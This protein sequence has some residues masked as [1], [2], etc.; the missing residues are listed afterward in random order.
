MGG[1]ESSDSKQGKTKFAASLFSKMSWLA[2]IP[3]MLLFRLIGDER[4]RKHYNQ[5]LPEPQR[6][7]M[8]SDRMKLMIVAL[9]ATIGQIGSVAAAFAGVGV[10]GMGAG[11]V[12]SRAISSLSLPRMESLIHPYV[13]M[14]F[15]AFWFVGALSWFMIFTNPR[16]R[17]SQLMRALKKKHDH[18]SSEQD[19]QPPW[20]Y[21]GKMLF[22]DLLDRTGE[23]AVNDKPLWNRA[24]F[25]PT[26]DVA[27]IPGT[28]QYILTASVE[29]K[30]N[31]TMLYDRYDEWTAL[32]E[33]K[34][35][36]YHWMLGEYVN[37]NEFMWKDAYED[38]SILFVGQSGSGKT[39]AMKCWLTNFVCKHPTT[40]IVICDLKK[41]GDWDSFAPLTENGMVVKSTEE[42]LLAISYFEDIL[43]SRTEHMQKNGYKN[44]R[45]WS[46]A[47]NTVV[48]PVLLIVDEFPQM[49]GPLKWDVYSRRDQTPAN[50]LF[51]LY[52]T[53]RSFG[54]WV[55]LGSQF[56]GSD[57]VPSEMNKNIKLHV[58][59]KVGSS[60]E[61]MQWINDEAAFWLGKNVR[62]PDGSEDRQVGYAYV[63][64]KTAFVRY[65]YAD[66]WLIVHEFLKY[67]VRT[68]EGKEHIQARKMGIPM[69]IRDRLKN[70]GG[71]KKKLTSR[72]RTELA[73]NEAAQAKFEASYAE[74]R[75]TPHQSL[76][77]KKSPLGT[78]WN[79]NEPVEEY[80]ARCRRARGVG[81][82]GG[83]A[84]KPQ[85]PGG[86]GGAYGSA[87]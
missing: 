64:G 12:L 31:S 25:N 54:L 75:K 62:R 58:C 69:G 45:S 66:D 8:G 14:A 28:N 7:A 26:A 80:F 4:L 51:K 68:I 5:Y 30:S 55:V 56:S 21:P 13:P 50:V 47:E 15:A 60:G 16:S 53:G 33:D 10:Y 72:E 38:F 83:Q 9:L 37:R 79:P 71:N 70:F 20:Y 35:K 40:H 19:V 78:L 11:Y 41:T 43:N 61:S 49:N 86:A 24:N 76:A 82:A 59:L 44:I 46:E 85:G 63:D 81:G 87:G 29:K 32:V 42:A 23:E 17:H 74:L 1:K 3:L 22:I 65:W 27:K 39:E 34:S 48:P 77:S 84:G 36:L 18:G 67:G 2:L 6:V 52:T 73:A 57:A